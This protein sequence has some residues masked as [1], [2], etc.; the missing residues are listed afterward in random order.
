MNLVSRGCRL[1][2]A[3]VVALS[4]AI[5]VTV[6]V[7]SERTQAEPASSLLANVITVS[8]SIQAAINSASDG[9]SVF[10]PAGLYTESLTLDKAVSLLGADANT[11]IVHALANQRV[12]TGTGAGITQSTIISGLTFTGGDL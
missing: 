12:L 6:L 7:P 3:C 2:A 5:S 4:L 10:V 8:T 9:D 1:L 11:T